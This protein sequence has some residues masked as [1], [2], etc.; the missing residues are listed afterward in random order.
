MRYGRKKA[1]EE[2]SPAPFVRRFFLCAASLGLLFSLV[3]V[4]IEQFLDRDEGVALFLELGKRLAQARD[5]L[6]AVAATV[7]HQDDASA[8]GTCDALGDD[9]GSGFLPVGG[10]DVP[11]D[12]GRD[13]AVEAQATESSKLPPGERN[14]VLASWPVAFLMAS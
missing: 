14:T 13:D 8:A 2:E 10:V 6:G 11:S 1:L 7:V 9:V 3:G 4:A 12:L 5:R